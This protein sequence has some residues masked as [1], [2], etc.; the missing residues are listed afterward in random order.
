MTRNSLG[1]R[2]NFWRR[3]DI[4]IH[5][6]DYIH[7]PASC[8][9]QVT[10]QIPTDNYFSTGLDL[11]LRPANERRCY[12]V[13]ASP[14]GW[15]QTQNQ[16]WYIIYASLASEELINP[17]NVTAAI[18]HFNQINNMAAD[19]VIPSMH[20]QDPL[21]LTWNNFYPSTDN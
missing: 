21:L 10:V 4:D 9:H 14:I 2:R 7:V 16:P 6:V 11:T 5:A 3:H 8:G 17:S 20:R 12:K 13:T 19:V 18:S 1:P 15:A